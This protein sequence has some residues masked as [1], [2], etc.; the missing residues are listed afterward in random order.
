MLLHMSAL[1]ADVHAT[2]EGD[3]TALFFAAAS[4]DDE[5]VQL[6][7]DRGEWATKELGNNLI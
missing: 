2:A 6:L 5:I 4:G 3:A 1:G 7:L